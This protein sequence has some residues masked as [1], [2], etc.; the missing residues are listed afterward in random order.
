MRPVRCHGVEGPLGQ[1]HDRS[2]EAHAQPVD[3]VACRVLVG[4]G[5]LVGGYSQRGDAA[6]V[7]HV[8]GQPQ[9]LGVGVEVAAERAR[10][11]L[12]ADV[13]QAVE[14]QQ[15]AGGFAAGQSGAG[16]HFLV[17]GEGGAQP[18]LADHPCQDGD[19]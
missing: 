15:L 16:G 10:G 2:A 4:V 17:A 8:V 14:L 13:G 1:L 5:D 11:A 3:T 19:E 9:G 12:E 7:G 6:T 18:V